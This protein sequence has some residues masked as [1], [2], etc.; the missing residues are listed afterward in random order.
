M[1]TPADD[2]TFFF[3]HTV[4]VQTL[5]GVNATGKV[6][7]A[8]KNVTGFLEGKIQLVRSKEG[9]EVVSSSQ[10]Y[11]SVSDGETFTPDSLVT[12]ASGRVARVISVNTNEADGLLEGVEHAVVYLK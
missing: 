9:E 8:S 6:Y 11:C 1:T 2:I 12:P 5:L 4:A 7:A 3:V 10:F